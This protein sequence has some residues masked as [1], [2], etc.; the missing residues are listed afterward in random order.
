MNSEEVKRLHDFL[1]RADSV[2]SWVAHRVNRNVLGD[3][4]YH[5]LL[6]VS[7]EARNRARDLEK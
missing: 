2:T 3:E 5:E 4:S 7:A 6:A 1:I